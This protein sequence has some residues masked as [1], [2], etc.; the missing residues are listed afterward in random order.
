MRLKLLAFAAAMAA[1]T[2]AANAA[3]I[4]VPW[5]GASTVGSTTVIDVAPFESGTFLGA[6]GSGFFG[7]LPGSGVNGLL[8]ARVNGTFVLISVTGFF[9]NGTGAALGTVLGGSTFAPGT[10]DQ[11]RLQIFNRGQGETDESS[12]CD[13]YGGCWRNM[14]TALFVFDEIVAT[15]VPEPAGLALLGAGLLGLGLARRSR[16]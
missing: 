14:T 3:L 5:T 9:T 12:I 2:P 8:S 13:I 6:A 1:F 7:G 4:N 16:R 10:I 15:P 11:L